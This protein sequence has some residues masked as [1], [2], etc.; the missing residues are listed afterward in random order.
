[1][2]TSPAYRL[3]LDP[4]AHQPGAA[5]CGLLP[6]SRQTLPLPALYCTLLSTLPPAL[7]C[8]PSSAPPC[9]LLTALQ[10]WED[11]KAAAWKAWKVGCLP[12]QR[13]SSFRHHLIVACR[14]A[15][16]VDLWC[17]GSAGQGR[18]LLCWLA[19]GHMR[20]ATSLPLCCPAALGFSPLAVSP[21]F[22]SFICSSATPAWPSR[23]PRARP[24]RLMTTPRTP[25]PRPTTAPCSLPTTSGRQVAAWIR[26]RGV[27]TALPAIRAAIPAKPAVHAFGSLPLAAFQ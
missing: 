2:I 14:S 3:L 10:T 9:A 8:A 20:H 12:R 22:L 4:H 7:P 24:T 21:S 11:A 1:M 18:P 27:S 19:P 25:P 17:Q 26:A 16:L 13:C 23:Q 6:E 15:T 5:Q